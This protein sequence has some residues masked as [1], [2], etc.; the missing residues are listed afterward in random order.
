MWLIPFPIV[1]DEILYEILDGDPKAAPPT[2]DLKIEDFYQASDL[3]PSH[4]SNF[5]SMAASYIRAGW[6]IVLLDPGTKKSTHKGWNLKVSINNPWGFTQDV[7]KIARHLESG[8]N[9]GLATVPSGIASFDIDDLTK[10]SASFKEAGLQEEF[11]AL[12]G[13]P[14]QLHIK[15]GREGRDKILFRV[16]EGFEVATINQSAKKGFELRFATR[17]GFTIQDVLPPSIHPDT[18]LPYC[19]VLV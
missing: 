12:L 16:P 4:K 19:Y 1:Y 11:E 13:A 6:H 9:I 10:A 15:S 14:D 5:R 17:E 18:G 2:P 7:D 8:G 3:T